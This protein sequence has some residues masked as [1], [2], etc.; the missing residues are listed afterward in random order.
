MTNQGNCTDYFSEKRMGKRR[1]A[2]SLT[3]IRNSNQANT[4]LKLK[5]SQ[6]DL[7]SK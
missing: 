5:P 7:K 6:H 1:S 2:S 4:T 3:A